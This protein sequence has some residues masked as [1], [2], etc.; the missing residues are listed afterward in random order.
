M[1]EIIIK[2]NCPHCSS[3]RVKKNGKK[4]S[5]KQNFY[6]NDCKKQFQYEYSYKGACPKNK[7]LI[8]TMTLNGSGIR[9]IQRV[10][11]L[12]I[13]CILMTLRY[14]FKQIPE[15]VFSGNYK[16][17]QIDEFWSFVKN[18]KQGKRWV[19]YVYD[20]E[21]GKILAFQIGKRNNETCKKL[22]K[23]IS[24]LNIEKYCTDDWKPYKKNIP[25]DKHIISKKKTTHIERRNK[26]FR[27]HLK[28][29]CRETACFSKANDMHYG[30][31]KA[32]IYYRN[33]A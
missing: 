13:I 32:Y 25:A 3:K 18:R 26:D 27:T 31:I 15:P 19:W 14:W 23:K 6:C 24:H 28:R 30:V 8:R 33:A 4:P 22:M 9:D 2:V 5:G 10:L 17:V 16:E 29:L 21:T 7:H 20:K 11:G 12:S 1:A